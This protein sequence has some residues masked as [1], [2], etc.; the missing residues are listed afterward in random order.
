MTPA[1]PRALTR[2]RIAYLAARWRLE[3]YAVWSRNRDAERGPG[4]DRALDRVGSRLASVELGLR[5]WHEGWRCPSSAPRSARVRPGAR[6][7]ASRSRPPIRPPRT[8]P[9]RS[10]SSCTCARA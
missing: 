9:D 10:D 4:F 6:L 8:A 1:S 7:G 3:T 5:A 2:E